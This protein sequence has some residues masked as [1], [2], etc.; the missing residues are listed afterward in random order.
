MSHQ[1]LHYD[2]CMTP[3]FSMNHEN[4]VEVLFFERGSCLERAISKNDFGVTV[5]KCNVFYK[6]TL[7]VNSLL[8]AS[9]QPP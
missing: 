9:Y 1:C 6:K 2:K 5:E 7:W 3:V 8:I 4:L